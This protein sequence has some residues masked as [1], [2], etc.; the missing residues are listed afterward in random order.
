MSL[1][2]KMMINSSS[3]LR[4]CSGRI[5]NFGGKNY[6]NVIV[7]ALYSVLT[8]L[9][10]YPA[11]FISNAVPGLGDVYFYLWDV[12][13]FKKAL[14]SLSSPYWTPYL[15]HPEG[16]SLAFSTITPLNGIFSVPIQFIFSVSETYTVL[17]L[18][19]FLAAGYGTY[20][21]V[22]YL[23]NDSSA[24][25]I[26]GIIFMFSPYHFAHA[27][28][29]LSLISIG[30]IPLY[31]LFLL[32]TL[33]ENN[34]KN[35]ILASLF[36]IFVGLSDTTYLFYVVS[37]TVLILAYF[38]ISE[39]EI[40]LRKQVIKRLFGVALISGIVIFPSLFPLLNEFRTSTFDYFG[41]S[42]IVIYSS[43][44]LAFLLPSQLHP[45]LG[46]FVETLYQNITGGI[47]E[48]TIFPGYT[49]IFLVL[50]AII[51]IKTKEI[52]FWALSAG[53]FIV[54]SLGPVLHLNGIVTGII[55]G[56]KVAIAL[57]YALITKIPLISIAR[58]PVRWDVMIMLSFSVLAGYGM[59]NIFSRFRGM[60]LTDKICRPSVNMVLCVILSSLILFEFLAVPFPM[61]DLSIPYFY[62]TIKEDPGD[63]AVL[64]IPGFVH[65][66]YMYYQTFHEKKLVTGYAHIP[67][68]NLKFIQN[69]P[70]IK[71]L[72]MFNQDP[73]KPISEQRDIID[74]D[75]QIISILNYYSIK[76]VVIHWTDLSPE[77]T[78][79][80]KALSGKYFGSTAPLYNTINYTLYE[81]P[82]EPIQDF[83]SLDPVGLIQRTG[84]VYLH[85][86]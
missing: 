77:Q 46:K 43:D 14:L 57:P 1:S 34:N 68:Q 55:D 39:R 54:L 44:L 53:G 59:A 72:L 75:T 64:E 23:T 19:S 76:Y 16:L 4:N 85:D 7:I 21:L 71:N 61:T 56:E 20:L 82:E 41:F 9:F 60:Y 24:S 36:L 26:A 37:F 18:F 80:I 81:M 51:K 73:A 69:N 78:A 2:S 84:V 31:I 40:L 62:N 79:F 17:W 70:A 8:I 50:F 25:F 27:L 86:G 11:I 45:L 28:G 66:E 38:F 32:K 5:K 42:G 35:V 3:L 63:V 29:H 58:V 49:V 83:V 52:R 6:L 15:F 30:W 65:P 10:T 12:W 67:D 13:W 22:N 74:Q 47:A 48:Y 33:R